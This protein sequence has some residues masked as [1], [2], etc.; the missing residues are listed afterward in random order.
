[1]ATTY[2]IKD[3]EKTRK[4][5]TPHGELYIIKDRC[6]GCG[7]CIEFCPKKVLVE[8]KEF[9]AKGYHPPELQEDET[10]KCINCGFCAMICPEFAIFSEADAQSKDVGQIPEK[11]IP[12]PESPKIPEIKK[13]RDVLTGEHF[14]NG[15]VAA[16]EGAIAAGCKFF[17][18]YPI[19]PSTEVAE[20]IAERM[21]QIGGVYVQM[22]DEIASI[23]AVL[24]A[25]WAGVKAMTA[26]S[27]PGFSLMQENIGLGAMTETPCLIIN[28]QRGGPS[29]G[30][31]TLVAQSDVMQAKWGTH[32]D[33]EIIALAPNSPQECFDLTIECFNLAYK[34]RTPVVL[35]M[36]ESVGHMTERVV[37]P[38]KSKIKLVDRKK[39]K[40]EPGKVKIYEADED[41]VPPMP[42]AGEGYNIHMTGLTHDERGYPSTIAETQERMIKRICDKIRVHADEI[43]RYEEFM[44]EDA[45][46]V[47]V[48]YGITSRVVKRA[49]LMAREKGIKAGMLRLITIWPFP[50][51]K[52]RELAKK[53]KNF[54]VVEIN[55]GQIVLEV[56][57][58]ACP[59]KVSFLG[60]MGGAVH[61]PEEVLKKMM[62][63]C[64]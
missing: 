61:T 39:P 55:Y 22:E 34:Y 31:P 10:K 36:D 23:A 1:M 13:A 26:T 43:V 32:G 9:N 24:G 45:E 33:H 38:E 48:A 60:K 42:Y 47:V 15:D 37:V 25:A 28:V 17:A 56:E 64:K 35:L 51:K 11:E 19:T 16:A 18:G 46:V 4:W 5:K 29:T 27:G 12:I 30:L 21:P 7:F 58:C 6:K 54:L 62:E 20:H 52:V 40:G 14:W 59:S 57:R 2:I 63:V 8:S 53:V 44:T 50:E 41:L 3:D 49:V